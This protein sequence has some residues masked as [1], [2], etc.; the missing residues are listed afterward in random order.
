MFVRGNQKNGTNGGSSFVLYKLVYSFF[1]LEKLFQYNITGL[2]RGPD[3]E[4]IHNIFT[5]IYIYIWNPFMVLKRT[6][7]SSVMAA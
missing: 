2:P 1:I 3:F 4:C 5:V 6:K 7:M